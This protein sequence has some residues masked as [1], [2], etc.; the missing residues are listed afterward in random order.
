[1]HR[2]LNFRTFLN[3]GVYRE[4]DDVTMIEAQSSENSPSTTPTLLLVS[5]NTDVTSLSLKMGVQ[6]TIIATVIAVLCV[7]IVCMIAAIACVYVK[8]RVQKRVLDHSMSVAIADLQD[9]SIDNPMYGGG[10]YT[11]HSYNINTR[12]CQVVQMLLCTNCYFICLFL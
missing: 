12:S 10:M 3:L 7:I 9:N 1:M 8:R 2:V 6:D 4:D 5:T 11:E